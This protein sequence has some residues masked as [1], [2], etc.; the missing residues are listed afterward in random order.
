MLKKIKKLFF[1]KTSTP[2]VK[3]VSASTSDWSGILGKDWEQIKRSV[4]DPTHNAPRVLLAT[5]MGA[6][7]A[8]SLLESTLAVSLTLRNAKVD[9]L[10]DDAYLPA[11]QITTINVGNVEEMLSPDTLPF[12]A[13]CQ[14]SGRKMFEPLG[15]PIYWY[16]QLVTKEQEKEAQHISQSVPY[17]EIEDFRLDDLAVGE[18]A[19]AGALRYFA[20]GDLHNEPAGETILRLYLKSALLSVYVIRALL[21]QNKYDVAC[22]NH[23][24]YTPQGLIGEVCRQQGVRVVNWN[25]AYRKHSFVFSHNDSYHHTMITE[26][27]AQWE[28]LPWSQRLEAPLMDYLDS[29]KTGAQ[30][31]IWFHEKPEEKLAQI[32]EETGVDFSKPVIAALTSVMWDAKLHYKSN[33]FS[34]MVD[35]I[36]FTIE[37]FAGRPDLQLLIRV[38]P[39]EVRGTLPSRQPLMGE[40]KRLFPVLPPNVFVIP[41]ES[42]V[43]TYAVIEQC[44][45]VIIYNTKTGIEASS[46]GIPVVVA[47][48]AWIRNKGFTSDASSPEAYRQLLDQLPGSRRMSSAQLE[49][50]RKY[51]FHFFFRRMI[52]L[53]FIKPV[54]PKAAKMQLD[55]KH[56]EELDPGRFK[57]LDIICA[58]IL[59]GTEF[60]YPAEIYVSSEQIDTFGG[61]Q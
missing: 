52:P 25:P 46:V 18:H 20:R 17:A 9:I 33:A 60:E 21:K 61:A 3:P 13:A 47:G 44:D 51:A 26:P 12:C 41:P 53:P 48:E 19:L 10:L 39:A 29:R 11:C 49:R 14:T 54:E 36:K 40:I 28:N 45:T 38:H 15:L 6:F 37:Y 57:G 58:G 56:L 59:D 34:N 32:S 55:I 50:A 4:N 16:S 23:G 35:W 8:G 1:K 7:Q 2:A 42:Q 27:V 22:F 43:S 31:W 30:D 24:I 5:S